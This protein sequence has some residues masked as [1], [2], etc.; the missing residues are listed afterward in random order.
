[1]IKMKRADIVCSIVLLVF[2][3]TAWVGTLDF[4]EN[5]AILPRITIGLIALLSVA[6]IIRTLIKASPKTVTIH[7]NRVIPLILF[8]LAYAILMTGLGFYISTIVYIALV[9]YWYGVRN[10]AALIGVPIGFCIF[11]FL[12]FAQFLSLRLPQPF[13]L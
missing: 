3:A 11:A 8:T 10:K 5:A 9:M 12:C 6:Q 13:F 4:T 1:M 7:F 2:C